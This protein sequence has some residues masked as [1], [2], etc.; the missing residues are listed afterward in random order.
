M[1]VELW[2]KITPNIYEERVRQ[3]DYPGIKEAKVVIING[4]KGTR[5]EFL[6]RYNRSSVR[7]IVFHRI[8]GRDI[9]RIEF[10]ADETYH[11]QAIHEIQEAIKSLKFIGD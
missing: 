9:V 1:P 5:F 7:S 8:V 11:P 3:A 4:H 6:E 2:G 10:S